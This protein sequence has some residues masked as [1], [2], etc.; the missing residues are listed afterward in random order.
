MK[1]II[2]LLSC[3]IL[4]GLFTSCE[5]TQQILKQIEPYATGAGGGLSTTD[6]AS[7]LKQALDVGAQNSSSKLSAVD[8]FF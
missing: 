7:A 4:L 3:V 5:S 8:G 6:S 1:K 2:Q